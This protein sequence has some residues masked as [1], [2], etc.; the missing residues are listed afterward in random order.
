MAR[1]YKGSIRISLFFWF[2][3]IAFIPLVVFTV[4]NYNASSTSLTKSAKENILY[5]SDSTTKFVRDW[6][7]YREKEVQYI[8][9][10]DTTRLFLETLNDALTDSK[11]TLPNF[12]KSDYKFLI[13]RDNEHDIKNTFH[14]YNYIADILLIDMQGNIL[15]N[16][17]QNAT[18][19]ANLKSPLYKQTK[20]SKTFEQT[21]KDNKIHYSDLEKFTPLHNRITSFITAP[22]INADGITIGVLAMEIKLNSLLEIFQKRNTDDYLH[23][24]IGT[25]GLLRS[26]IDTTHKTLQTKITTQQ[27][28]L[29]YKEHGF[30]GDFD[31]NMNETVF[32]YKG[33][34]GE[35]VLGVHD[36]VEFLGVKW[37]LISEV[38]AKILFQDIDA[39]LQKSIEFSIFA[40]IVVIFIAFFV[41]SN[42]A[43]P[44]KKLAHASY[45]FANG[46]RDIILENRQNNEIGELTNSFNSMIKTV[47]HNEEK[48][49]EATQKAQESTQAKSEFL[50]S[51]SHEI[52]TP[53]NGVIGMLELLKNSQLT[54]SQKNHLHVA[55]SS[56]HALLTLI[57]DILDF[58]KVEAG[59]MEIES[60][61][62]NLRNEFGDLAKA[63]V[64]KAEEKGVELVLD[65]Q[66]LQ[67][68]IILSDPG[69][70]R[71]ITTN[72][73]SNAIKFTSEGSILITVTLDVTDEN[74][75]RLQVSV[76][77]TGIGI[78]EDKIA[79]L[80]DSFSQVDAST[81][82]KYG[83]TGLGLA[84]VKK[85]CALMDGSVNA[86]SVIDKGSIF[87]FDIG[88]QLS[89]KK[90]L[91]MPAVS[92]KDKRVLIVDDNEI[93]R[94]VLS[95]QLELWN[96]EV[97][98]AKDAQ[99]A[100][101]MCAK[102][103]AHSHTPPF[104]IA[105]L[106]MQM[107]Q[108]DGAELGKLLRENSSYD[109]M[110]LVM[111]TS[112]GFRSDAAVFAELGFDAFF[113]KPTTAS[114]L[115]DALN[116]LVEN[117]KAKEQAT[118]LITHEYLGTLSKTSNILLVEDNK[119]NQLVIDGLLE[120]LGLECDIANN[121]V[122]A[123]EMLNANKKQYDLILMDCQMPQMDGYEA[124]E[125]IRSGETGE[126]NKNIPILALTANAMQGD[127][128]KCYLAGMSDYLAKPIEA[129]KFTEILQK[130]LPKD[131]TI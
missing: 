47:Q 12:L 129:K 85:L 77:D 67:Q 74:N 91:R 92:I 118:P 25:D 26:D 100:L 45:Q 65:M 82:R 126:I 76:Q 119:T 1:H 30:N 5:S 95:G 22:V 53:M 81:T 51:M 32:F 111:M 71:Q 73:V 17:T 116:I 72:L 112:L 122:E 23:Y 31:E 41:S 37:A 90:T 104:D 89:E 16:I 98:C 63:L 49:M 52:R 80:F 106:D 102:A 120:N 70:I 83:G 108:M 13:D 42:I 36:D 4:L 44:L 123:L 38:N 7:T 8:S 114:D 78:P 109:S 29:W 121:G 11:Q 35:K 75:A 110:K 33:P 10:N 58:S 79:S 113:S 125:N 9:Q 60:I 15:Y 66:G 107:P 57:N 62:F 24:F 93:N 103:L 20:F 21:L 39:V 68:E 40:L 55:K 88:V 97:F 131:S 115:F 34:L 59:K 18:L 86:T 64:F 19:G 3:L 127:Q 6:F 56:A 87:S 69:R 130:W 117:G 46:K 105:F 128:E 27:F 84:I 99:E 48:L 96:M 14:I 61:A 101:N 94:R 124:T 50:A 28:Q 2:L 43:K 54:P